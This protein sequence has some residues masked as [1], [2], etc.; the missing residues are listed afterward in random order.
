MLHLFRIQLICPNIY[1]SEGEKVLYCFFQLL[2]A[3]FWY[4]CS[5]AKWSCRKIGAQNEVH[6][7]DRNSPLEICENAQ[8]IEFF[9]KND[10]YINVNVTKESFSMLP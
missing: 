8:L 7:I 4:I 3:K 9:T 2:D 1:F 10:I 6:W 5:Y